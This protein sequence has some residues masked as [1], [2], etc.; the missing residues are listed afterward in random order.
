[1]DVKDQIA[2]IAQDLISLEINTIVQPSISTEKMPDARHALIDLAQDYNIALA[3]FDRALPESDTTRLGSF[4]S[5]DAIR[6]SASAEIAAIQKRAEDRELT[7]TESA[8]LFLLYRI[9]RVSDQ[10]K[11]VFNRLKSRNANNWDNNLTRQEIEAARDPLPLTSDELVILRKAW[12]IGTEE[13]AMQTVIQLDGDVVTRV[14]PK[15][16]TSQYSVLHGIHHQGIE[17]SVGFWKTLVDIVGS[18]VK[19]IGGFVF[20]GK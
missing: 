19:T 20:P 7:D 1:M 6:E 11:S 16:A 18:I 9:K 10:I 2:R 13:V 8:S 3:R 14:Q 12:E 5:F 15:F 17:T 4:Q